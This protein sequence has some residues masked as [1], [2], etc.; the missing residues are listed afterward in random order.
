MLK[1][2]KCEEVVKSLTFYNLFNLL[3][4]FLTK[5]NSP[6]QMIRFGFE[7]AQAVRQA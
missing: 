2:L 4:L 7:P 5:I 3:K 6:T 1:G